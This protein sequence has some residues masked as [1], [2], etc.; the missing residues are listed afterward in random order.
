MK[1]S[2]TL[3]MPNN[4]SW[5]GKW[6]GDNDLYV[7]IKDFGRTKKG[8]ARAEELLKQPY[9][10]YAFGDGWGAS[11]HLKEVTPEEAR[12]LKKKSKGFCG[13]DWMVISI[14]DHGRIL[15]IEEEKELKK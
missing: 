2:F 3:R 9:H 12:K 5:D 7:I 1:I 11:V 13:Y 4:N 10:Y 8:N 15:T 6:S 14:L